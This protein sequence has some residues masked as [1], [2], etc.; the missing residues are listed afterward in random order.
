MTP[1]PIRD[2]DVMI[3]AGI[4]TALEADYASESLAWE[5]SPFAWIKT[6]PSRQIG[7]IGEKLVAGY[8]AA[9]DFDVVKS[10]NSDADRKIGGLLTEIKFSTRWANGQYK[11]QQLRDQAYD[12]AICLGV[13]PFDA[14]CWV[15][16]KATIL[17][18]W[19][20]AR[21]LTSQHGGQ[22]GRDT[23]WLD[24][25]PADVPEWLSPFGGSL[26][27]ATEVFR[28]L[29]EVGPLGTDSGL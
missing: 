21:G 22:R 25:N 24:V 8:F 11:F 18:G 23:A 1:L 2:P 15:L 16:P 28:Q 12:V 4:A 10:P 26:R 6:R 13:C 14:H 27:E 20:T 3:L 5:G 17:S 7:A 29:A 9:K 19:G